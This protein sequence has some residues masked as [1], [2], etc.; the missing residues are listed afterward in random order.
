MF[1][2]VALV[3]AL[4][5]FMQRPGLVDGVTLIAAVLLVHHCVD[6]AVAGVVACLV[7]ASANDLGGLH[8]VAEH[9]KEDIL[10]NAQLSVPGSGTLPIGDA[11]PLISGRLGDTVVGGPL[12]ADSLIGEVDPLHAV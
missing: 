12:S 5:L 10:W 8:N 4:L 7:A 2:L 3:N 6:R 1:P 11:G 9:V